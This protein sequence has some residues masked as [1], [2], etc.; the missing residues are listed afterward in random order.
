[1]VQ[2]MAAAASSVVLAAQSI[3]AA[4]ASWAS[5]DCISAVELLALL[6]AKRFCQPLK[7]HGLRERR[8]RKPEW[9]ITSIT[10]VFA[11]RK[12]D[13]LRGC[14]RSYTSLPYGRR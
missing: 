14:S 5:I 10:R 1:M 2:I 7:G 12:A 13:G 11:P 4:Y 8:A 6:A 3:A 9:I